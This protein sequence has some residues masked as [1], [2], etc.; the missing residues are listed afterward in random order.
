[1]PS[2]LENLIYAIVGGVMTY[3]AQL[4]FERWKNRN[5]RKEKIEQENDTLKKVIAQYEDIKEI[6]KT[7]NKN[8]GSTYYLRKLSNGMESD[9]ICSTCWEN[10]HKTI[11]I[12][13]NYDTGYFICNV[14]KQQ[15]IFD[16][17]KVNQ[18]ESRKKE[19][20]EQ[21]ESFINYGR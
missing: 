1:M 9:K 20:D 11:P 7:L 18:N 21:Y 19:N 5:N 14:C 10:N 16:K 6:E 8:T 4:F 3:F 12:N 2:W 13:C 15:A 17:E